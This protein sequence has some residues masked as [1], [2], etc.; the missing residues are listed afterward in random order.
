MRN[1]W[2]ICIV[3]VSECDPEYMKRVYLSNLDKEFDIIGYDKLD[4]SCSGNDLYRVYLKI[5]RVK[6]FKE[7][8][9][10]AIDETIIEPLR[11]DVL[12]QD[13]VPIL[14]KLPASFRV[15]P[16]TFKRVGIGEDWSIDEL[17]M[18]QRYVSAWKELSRI[19]FYFIQMG[20][21]KELAHFLK[22]N[23]PAIYG[24]IYSRKELLRDTIIGEFIDF[25]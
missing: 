20:E 21:E 15:K 25:L 17:C 16:L 6:D 7:I 19:I 4:A 22:T 9:E 14:N 2:D 10:E 5:K 1:Q 13:T 3:G 23:H 24:E 8:I 12:V 18:I 11:G